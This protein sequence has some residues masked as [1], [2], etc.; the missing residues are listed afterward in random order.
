MDVDRQLEETQGHRRPL[1]RGPGLPRH[2]V[3]LDARHDIEHTG[4]EMG[5]ASAYPNDVARVLSYLANLIDGSIQLRGVGSGARE[6][7][8]RFLGLPPPRVVATTRGLGSLEFQLV[9]LVLGRTM[10][11]NAPDAVIG[12]DEDEPPR[13]EQLDLGDETVSVPHTLVA[14]FAPGTIAPCPLVVS[15][16][17][18]FDDRFLVRVWSRTDDATEAAG[19]LDALLAR[20]RAD[21]PFRRRTLRAGARREFGLCFSVV[22]VPE[23]TREELILPAT[24][25][26]EV[27]VCVHGLFAGLP[28]LRAAGLACNRG[29]LL[30]GPPGTGKTGVCRVLATELDEQV[31]IVFCDAKAVQEVIEDLYRELVHLAPALVVM[32]DLDLVVGHRHGGSR[33][34]VGFLLALDGAMT[35]H[36]GVVTVATTNDPDAIDAAARRA[37][38]FDRIVY[39]GPPDRE[40]RAAI[41]R[42]YLRPLGCD[43]DV[44]RVAASTAGST[45][46]DLRELVTRAVLCVAGAG[47]RGEAASVTTELLLE[48]ARESAG[49]RS[50]GQYL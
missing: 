3:G 14:A 34:L 6:F 11:E 10:R 50:P 45:G 47:R 39:V 32:E 29:V 12:E 38:R 2:D 28:Q 31:T 7:A 25:W 22:G 17:G 15:L 18:S 16:G 4:P 1:V 13:Y 35:Q 44:D 46:A 42:R 19:W 33:A 24:V 23:A 26:D 20:S 41:L 21:N 43:V 9:G 37:G 49:G 48:L 30:A 27:D 8:A 36:A 40:A 5:S